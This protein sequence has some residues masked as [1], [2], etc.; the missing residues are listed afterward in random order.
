MCTVTFIPLKDRWYITSNRDEKISRKPAIS[1]QQ[2]LINDKTLIF[3]KDADA[4]GTW[5]TVND[6]GTAGVLLN[7]AFN[8]HIPAP[9]YGKSRGLIFLEIITSLD[10]PVH[11]R[12]M[13]LSEIEPFSLILLSQSGLQE[14]RWDGKTRYCRE[15]DRNIPHIWSS[16]TLYDAAAIRKREQWFAQWLKTNKCPGPNGIINFHRFTGEDNLYN[17]LVM[18]RRNELLTVSITSIELQ[19]DRGILDY[20][21]LSNLKW[22]R[23][24]LTFISS[25]ILP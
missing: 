4:G 11:F 10:P 2:Y 24:Q 6:N 7:G 19:K 16:V 13:D 21:D 22:S 15:I 17:D 25:E 8:K 5:I 18:N 9:S 12:E 3:P 23:K 20:L 14:C 1:P